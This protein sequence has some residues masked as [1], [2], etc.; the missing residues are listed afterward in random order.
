MFPAGK[1][2]LFVFI[3]LF[4]LNQLKQTIYFAQQLP[5]IQFLITLLSKRKIVKQHFGIFFPNVISLSHLSI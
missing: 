4:R 3:E 2:I 1:Y 5:L